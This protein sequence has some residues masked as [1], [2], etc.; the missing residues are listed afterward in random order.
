MASPA[1]LITLTGE[2][3]P[4]VTA[5]VTACLARDIQRLID[6]EQIV[7]RQRLTLALLCE[8]LMNFD[9][10]AVRAALV[11]IAPGFDVD[12]SETFV[13]ERTTHDGRDLFV[14]TVLAMVLTPA[15]LSEVATAIAGVGGNIER[16]RRTADYPVTALEFHVSVAKAS[17]NTAALRSGLLASV[18]HHGVDISVQRADLDRHGVRLVV[19]DVDSTLVQAEGID[20]LGEAAGAAEQVAA[21]T[22]AAMRGELDYAE[23]LRARVALL[24]GLSA[25]AVQDIARGIELSPGA[26]TLIRTLQ[27]CGDHV[28]LVSGGFED[29]ISVH[30]A[31]LG[32]S[33]V[34]ANRLGVANGALT[35]EVL[36][37]IVDREGKAAALV[38]FAQRVGVPLS[39]T[40]AI[41]DGANDLA[42][43]AVAGLGVAFNAKPVVREAADAT[44]SV[45]YLD[46]VLYMLGI[47]REQVEDADHRDGVPHH[48]PTVR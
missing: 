20:L 30:A 8:P 24:R 31:E 9:G 21:I 47:T 27:R 7:I 38:E 45:P 35:G 3:R 13:D 22:A 12:V 1:V 37:P 36:E 17:A 2:D 23:S 28:A 25:D 48:R 6:V 11:K 43:L 15:A 39:R 34:R 19:L 44:V 26:R 4:G 16:I 33:L 46:A 29:L 40:V 5:A 10:A 14:V 32:V 41:G 18:H 42:M